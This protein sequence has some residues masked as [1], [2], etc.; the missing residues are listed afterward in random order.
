SGR[1]FEHRKRWLEERLRFLAGCFGIDLLGFAILSNHFHLILR[2]RPDVVAT[3]DDAEV[4]RRWLML[5]PVRK[6]PAGEPEEPTDAEIAA[7]TGV[8][9]RLKEIRRRLCDIS[10]LMRM[11]TEPLARRANREDGVS[12]RFWEGRFKSV[13][14]CD[15]AA[16]LAC[17][18]YVDLNP[19]RAGL[20]DTPEDSDF[21]SAQRRIEARAQQ[22]EQHATAA[23]AEPASPDDWLAPLPLAESAADPG[24]APSASPARCSDRGFLPMSVDD[25]LQLLDWTGRRLVHGK[26]GAIPPDLAPILD[27][28]QIAEKD[29]LELAG[30]FGRLFQRVAGRAASIARLRTPAGRTFRPGHARLLGAASRVS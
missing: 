24:P 6:T 30:G 12:G 11:A 5:C 1:S 13:K 2:N 17:G 21:T 9:E 23:S 27:R 4:A 18:V 25:Y 28:L 8:P 15:E 7:I 19:I 26:H 16:I 29:W 14:L 20:A 22:C 3:W 10:W